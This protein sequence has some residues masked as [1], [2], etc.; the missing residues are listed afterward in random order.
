MKS[1]R[2]FLIVVILV[3]GCQNQHSAWPD[4]IMTSMWIPADAKD[5]R[6]DKLDDSYQI[7]YKVNEC[8]PG[9]IFIRGMVGEMTRKGW[10]R[11]DVDFLDPRI[12]LNHAQL[13]GDIW[14]HFRDKNGGDIYQWLDDWEDSQRNFVRYGL[15]YQAK[16]TAPEN[17]CS[18]EVVIICLL[19]DSRPRH[20]SP[21][22]K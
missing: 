8:Y 22:I 18:L 7:R 6:Y 20:I 16:H 2:T 14:S 10:Q 11:L 13:P 17:A 3:V 21:T 5:I 15:K 1:I 12:K 4:Y 9:S 19:A